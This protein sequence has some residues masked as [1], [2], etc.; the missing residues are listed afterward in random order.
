MPI[1][2]D[3]LLKTI[4][5]ERQKLHGYAWIVVGDPSAAEDVVQEACLQAVKN[6]ETINDEQHLKAWLRESIRIRGMAAR[7][8]R[9]DQAT[10]LSQQVLDLL[11][12]TS[13]NQTNEDHNKRMDAL[14]HCIDLLGDTSRDTLALRYGKGMKPAEIAEKTGRPL[15]AVYKM[16]TRSH[17][18][19]RNCIL[20]RLSKKGGA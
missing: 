2:T 1:T 8:K 18:A 14:R 6:A 12:Q 19:L 7:R 4:M 9:M 16:I 5:D 15:S 20:D 3:Q 11:A 17:A 13:T 10:Q